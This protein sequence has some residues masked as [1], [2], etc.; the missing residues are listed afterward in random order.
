MAA[1]ASAANPLPV[2]RGDARS[3]G[4]RGVVACERLGHIAVWALGQNASRP[5]LE[6]G[7]PRGL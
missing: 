4:A 6:R 3:L 5:W 7:P 2:P 1:T